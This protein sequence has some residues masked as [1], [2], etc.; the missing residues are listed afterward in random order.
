MGCPQTPLISTITGGRGLTLETLIGFDSA[1]ADN[2]PGAICA[3]TLQNG[4]PIAFEGPRLVHFAEA[5]EFIRETAG[6]SDFVLVALDQPT[7]V[8][9]LTGMRPTERVAGSVVNGLKG[10]VQPANRGRAEMFG[11][12]A[13]VWQFLDELSAR[14][15][16]DAA[17]FEGHGSFL[18]EVFPALALPSLLPE[19]WQRRRCAKYNPAKP[20]F[21]ADDWALVTD[22]VER[23]AFDEGMTGLGVAARELATLVKPRKADQDKLDALICLLIAWIFRRHPPSATTVIGDG[24]NGYIV[25]PIIPSIRDVLVHSAQ[26]IGVPIDVPWMQDAQRREVATDEQI[27]SVRPM[28]RR[29]KIATPASDVSAPGKR[30]PEC[31][32]LFRGKGWGGM[33]AHWR[34]HHEPIM[35]YE[36]AWQIIKAGA[37]PSSHFD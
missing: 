29:P 12:S 9:N 7:I 30:C 20:N 27:L 22:Y 35:P 25:T 11:N 31:G 14:E 15:N 32:H 34:A 13:P 17:R 3:I 36:D 4:S 21:N 6:N 18:I 33:D 8:P 2:A 16:P 37:K 5:L 24:E 1:W 19:V 23:F 28:E 26:L 10:G